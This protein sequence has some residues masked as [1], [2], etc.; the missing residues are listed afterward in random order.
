MRLYRIPTLLG[1]IGLLLLLGPTSARAMYCGNN[2]IQEGMTKLDVLSKCGAPDLKEVVAVNTFGL[3]DRRAFRATSSA[4]D[5]WYYNCG[6]GRFN[7]TLYFDG[8]T[9]AKIETSKTYGSGPE[10]YA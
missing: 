2:L 4:V 7:R 5:V 6:A 3:R 10:R 9:L 8:A 1:V